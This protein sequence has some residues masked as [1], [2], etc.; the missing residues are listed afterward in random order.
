MPNT[1]LPHKNVK[2]FLEMMT[3]KNKKETREEVD[4]VFALFDTGSTGGITLADMTRVAKDL[5]HAMNEDE[6]KEMIDHADKSKKGSVSKDDFYRLMMK[7]NTAKIDD[8]L[9]DDE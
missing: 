5:G 9:D 6:L 3:N 4:K 1:R 8:L 2:Q 7:Q